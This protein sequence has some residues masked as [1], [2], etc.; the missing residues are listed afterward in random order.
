METMT[1]SESLKLVNPFLFG[2]IFTIIYGV[3]AYLPELLDLEF[4]LFTDNLS[5]FM[6]I[7]FKFVS[8]FTLSGILWILALPLGLKLLKGIS[9]RDFII[10][11]RLL[12]KQ[13]TTRNVTFG[14]VASLAFV[15][16]VVLI[17]LLLGVFNPN[18]S[19]LVDPDYENGLGWFIFIFALIPG[20][21]E[22][23]AFRGIILSL[24]LSKYSVRKAMII[25]GFL[26]SLFH[27]F[28]FLILGQDLLSVLL[29]SFA[30]IFV[31]I[32]LAYLVIKTDSL[33][34]AIIIHYSIDVT[35]FISGFIFNLTDNTS[36]SIFAIFSLIILPPLVIYLST[37]IFEKY[38]LKIES[39]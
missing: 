23:I 9:S 15:S 21:W 7:F 27:V 25:D 26:F 14:I 37:L 11:L 1:L 19:L 12:P 8:R 20:I 18:F 38:N 10:S 39:G 22:E 29:Q 32:S 36:S 33:L 31:G 2:V 16:C 28:N 30:A 17:A 34:P 13:L 35:L 5:P 24:L 4:I 3:T 6:S